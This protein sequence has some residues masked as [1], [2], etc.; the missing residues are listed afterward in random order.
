MKWLQPDGHR[1][2]AV[3][4]GVVAAVVLLL[5]SQAAWAQDPAAPIE[6]ADVGW[7]RL[8]MP[9]GH[10]VMVYQPQLDAWENHKTL[11]ATAAV[12]VTPKG[13]K[14]P[15]YGALKLEAYTDTDF[16]RREVRLSD[17]Q[18]KSLT[19]PNV[20]PDAAAQCEK[21]VRS[22]T[23]RQTS[24]IIALDRIIAQVER[25]EQQSKEVKVNL[26]PPPIYYS[27]SPAILVIFIGDPKFEAIK[28]TSLLF[29][30][31]TN[32]D[33][34]LDTATSQYY[35]LNGE[36]WLTTKDP[37][38]GPWT[39]AKKLPADFSKLPNDENW[40]DVR[41]HIPGKPG[42]AAPKVIVTTKPSE[43]ILTKGTPQLEVIQNTKLLYITNTDS[44]LFVHVG[45]NASQYYFLTA[46]RWFRAKA[47]EGPWTSAMA[48]LPDDF[49]HIPEAHP[50][51]HVLASVPGTS[52]AEA[53]VLLASIPKTATVNRKDVTIKVAYDGAPKFETIQGTTVVYA[54]NTP[55]AVFRVENKFYC[56][57]QGIWFIS[58]AAT[59]P[60]AVATSVP[61]V[62][63]T[64]PAT[65]PMHNVTYVYVYNSTPET[66][67]VGQTS[68]YTG[69]YLAAGVVLFGLGYAIA[70]AD[71]VHV[72]YHYGPHY[73]GYGCAA[74]YDYYHG[75]YYRSA[76]A[77]GPYGGAGRAAAYNPATGTYGR[78]AYAY[79]PR[80]SAFAREAYNPHTGRY[81]GQVGGSNPYGSWGRSVVSN[82]DDWARAGHR[83]TARGTVG[84]AQGSDGGAV[85][86]GKN[87]WGDRAA[88]GTD[89]DGNVFVGK[90][91]NIYKRDDS[92]NWSHRD[93]GDWK[94]ANRTAPNATN[95]K[96]PQP[97]RPTTTE[98]PTPSRTLDRSTAQQLDRSART[99]DTGS[100]RTSRFQQQR[101]SGGRA[102]GGGRRR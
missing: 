50:R 61:P 21:I 49:K 84:A 47:L 40:A 60:W 86:A 13:A 70:N 73:W 71:D 99:R 102:G 65:S 64:I 31:N 100:A 35:L 39:P 4:I 90:D 30:V 25:A 67:T 93:D 9:D 18:I 58:G 27:D 97:D 11:K 76:H 66:V 79:G 1:G 48:D 6:S 53:A 7:P 56:C 3:R 91:G 55:S 57:D 77:Y 51:G 101:S 36:S 95:T 52:E 62:I 23:P 45:A 29:A 22:V 72:H 46:G 20:K 85:V 54:V 98:R 59:G 74:R 5:L 87:R 12:A 37:K 96:R 28:G 19:F 69:Q 8:F 10:R 43:L 17:V 42:Q 89:G 38:K 24:V 33:T 15:Y 81:A 44:D 75:G 2:D 34:L 94:A 26:E 83:S 16:A 78:A 80:G 41:K 32:W 14:E 88:V 68:G 92:G 82:G 63:Y